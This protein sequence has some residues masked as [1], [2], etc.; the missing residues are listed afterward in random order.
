MLSRRR[1]LQAAGACILGA[2]LPDPASL[3]FLSLAS[4]RQGTTDDVFIG[5]TVDYVGMFDRPSYS[6][7]KVRGFGADELIVLYEVL[8]AGGGYNRI[9]YRGDEGYVHSANV[10]PM[11]PYTAPSLVR[12]VSE[13]G[14]WAQLVSPWSDSRAEP[15]PDADFM[16][17]LY[18]ASV[19][20]VVQVQ[21]AEG[22][23]W[24]YQISDP[25]YSELYWAQAAH[26]RVIAPEELAPIHPEVEDKRIEVNLA[27]QWL[28]A[29]EGD[30]EVFQTRIASGKT[31][32]WEDGTV[33]CFE[34]PTGAHRVLLKAPARH[35]GSRGTLGGFDYPGVP[36][37]TFFTEAGLAIH[38]TYWHN[39][40]GAKRSHGCINVRPED[41]FWIYRWTNPE[42]PYESEITSYGAVPN[43]TPIYVF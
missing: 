41:A 1:F 36:W 38:G 29:Y 6:A 7:N 4:L 32:Y 37:C 3:S 27:A 8:E 15:R 43:T 35:M 22:G 19:H 2:R 28:F 12:D 31:F 39:D 42:A 18:Y 13:W 24:W 21:Q 5:R 14:V 11:H 34:T 25:R 23:G 26:L 10:V 33:D 30:V 16:Y 17:R 9:W 20:R 40:Y